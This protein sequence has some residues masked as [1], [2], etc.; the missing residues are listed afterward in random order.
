MS[1]E[2]APSAIEIPQAKM[3]A[4]PKKPRLG[5]TAAD[6]WIAI[7]SASGGVV[8]SEAGGRILYPTLRVVGGDDFQLAGDGAL[9]VVVRG[10]DGAGVRD[11]TEAEA[12]EFHRDLDGDQVQVLLLTPPGYGSDYTRQRVLREMHSPS[13]MSFKSPARYEQRPTCEI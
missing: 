7:K 11:A 3:S 9:R 6:L 4:R 10:T 2:S 5:E 12:A 8:C 1:T 13:G